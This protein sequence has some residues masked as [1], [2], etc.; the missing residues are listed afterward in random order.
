VYFQA[1]KSVAVCF[2]I[3]Q[4]IH[5]YKCTPRHT[6]IYILHFKFGAGKLCI[7]FEIKVT[8][9]EEEKNLSWGRA[10]RR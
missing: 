5:I 4:L 1:T 3:N 9:L 2:S 8:S 10:K 7:N 6:I